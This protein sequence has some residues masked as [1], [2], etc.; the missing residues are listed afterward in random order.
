MVA[1]TLTKNLL[2]ADRCAKVDYQIVH[3]TAGH[4]RIRV[5]RL[6]EDEV[7]ADR[8]DRL[9]KS[10]NF[11]T[12]AYI[13]TKA[14]SL[15]VNYRNNDI[16]IVTVQKHLATAIGRANTPTLAPHSTSTLAKR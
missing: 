10:F 4:I 3:A 12:N 7:Y 8:L 5:P 6:A 13:N 2:S 14:R 16:S 9:V 1:A 15:V 11:V